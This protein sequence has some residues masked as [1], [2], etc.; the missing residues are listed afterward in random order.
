MRRRKS[1]KTESLYKGA[2]VAILIVSA[3]ILFPM[4]PFELTKSHAVLFISGI[5]LLVMAFMVHLFR[6]D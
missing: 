2:V 4:L 3:L 5:F 6:V 1:N